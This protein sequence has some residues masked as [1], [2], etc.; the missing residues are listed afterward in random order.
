MR[1]MIP[2]IGLMAIPILATLAIAQSES[3]TTAPGTAPANPAAQTTTAPL[4]A[5]PAS[6]G[7]VGTREIADQSQEVLKKVDQLVFN[8]EETRLAQQI[9]Q[10]ELRLKVQQLLRDI[11]ELTQAPRTATP[12]EPA[13]DPRN[14]VN[15]PQ[16]PPV[17]LIGIVS[18]PQGRRAEFFVDG[19][20]RV[21]R[22]GQ[23]IRPGEV[24]EKIES[25]KVTI[26]T[27]SGRNVLVL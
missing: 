5:P 7:T 20:R 19:Y 4:P 22:E 8:D 10:L 15:I 17:R 3:P 11:R 13:P 24:V 18:G 6:P 26:R 23:E 9:R 12:Q 1:S 21:V 25:D 2:M 27:R 16:P 14:I